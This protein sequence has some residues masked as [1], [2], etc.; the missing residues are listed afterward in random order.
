MPVPELLARRG[1]KLDEFRQSI[2]RDVRYANITIIEGIGA[3]QYGIGMVAGR[4]AEVVLRDEQAVYP[5][6]AHNPRHGVALSLPS[7]IGRA[8]VSEVLWPAMS[9]EETAGVEKSAARLKE[10]VAT[11]VK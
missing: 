8:G 6:G 3:S 5:V 9:A 10:V 2:E 11:Y 4:I 1:L 7:V